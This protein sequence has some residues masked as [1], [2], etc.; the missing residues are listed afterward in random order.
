[1]EM[2]YVYATVIVLFG[3]L[4]AVIARLAVSWLKTKADTTDTPW[5]D[6]TIPV[7]VA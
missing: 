6:I 3:V 5:N 7:S 4:L 1:M 2:G